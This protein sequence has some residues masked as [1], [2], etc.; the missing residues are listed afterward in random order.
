[1]ERIQRTNTLKTALTGASI[2]EGVVPPGQ[3]SQEQQV[4]PFR[5]PATAD[6]SSRHTQRVVLGSHNSTTARSTCCRKVA[7]WNV[8]TLYQAGKVENIKKEARRLKLGS[9]GLSEAR[10]T[11]CGNITSGYWTFLFWLRK[12]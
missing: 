11:G 7:T 10:W 4:M 9:L 1:M 3:C 8:N 6:G 2:K 5:Y 12:A